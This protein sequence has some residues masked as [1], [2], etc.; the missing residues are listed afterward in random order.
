MALAICE[1]CMLVKRYPLHTLPGPLAG[2]VIHD[3][4]AN[5]RALMHDGFRCC[6]TPHDLN[7]G[8]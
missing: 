1:R 6:M 8:A 7:F 4:C 5:P 2:F 3:S